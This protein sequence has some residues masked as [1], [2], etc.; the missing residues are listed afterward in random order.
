A[1]SWF[2]L[3]SGLSR[4]P[5]IARLIALGAVVRVALYGDL[6][7]ERE[8]WEWSEAGGKRD[9]RSGSPMALRRCRTP[10]EA[11]PGVAIPFSVSVKRGARI[12][13]YPLPAADQTGKPIIGVLG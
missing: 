12:V 5:P 4:Y 3:L 10:A 13:F 2:R 11:C 6:W 1:Q 7:R 9:A 8:T